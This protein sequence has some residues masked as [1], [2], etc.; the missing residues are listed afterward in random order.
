M[1]ITVPCKIDK[2]SGNKPNKTKQAR[3]S[4]GNSEGTEGWDK[5]ARE[6]QT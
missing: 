2:V 4:K 6:V 3:L 5:A 1:V